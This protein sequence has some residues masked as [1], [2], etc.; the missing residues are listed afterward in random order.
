MLLMAR[1]RILTSVRGE[2]AARLASR[3]VRWADTFGLPQLDIG[4]PL[5]E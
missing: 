2:V 4:G 5:R 1:T 3:W